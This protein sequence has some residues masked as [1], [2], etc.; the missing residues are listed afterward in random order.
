M[1]N[2]KEPRNRDGRKNRGDR[3]S[4]DVRRNKDDKKNNDVRR[5]KDDKMSKD[6]K[7]NR[8]VRKSNAAGP[9]KQVWAVRKKATSSQIS[10]FRSDKTSI[11]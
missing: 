11:D 1:K 10:K 6:D 5:D 8:G 2:A 3:R 7:M 4:N 9:H